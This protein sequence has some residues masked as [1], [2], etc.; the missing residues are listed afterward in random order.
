MSCLC[1]FEI[2]LQ[3]DGDSVSISNTEVLCNGDDR[4]FSLSRVSLLYRA[5]K[6]L[7]FLTQLW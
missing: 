6:L 2:I 5:I 3:E 4:Y 7:E 1:L